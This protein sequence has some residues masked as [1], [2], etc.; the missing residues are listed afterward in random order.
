MPKWLLILFPVLALGGLIYW[1]LSRR[2]KTSFV[3]PA[4][5]QSVVG[6]SDVATFVNLLD[7]GD[8]KT[9]EVLAVIFK[10][11]SFI[12][13]AKAGSHYGLFQMY[14]PSLEDANLV[15][16]QN[17]KNPA[18]SV[19]WS[20]YK[21]DWRAQCRAGV[22][23]MR[24]C[25]RAAQSNKDLALKIWRVGYGCIMNG[26]GCIANAGKIASGYVEH[27][28]SVKQRFVKYDD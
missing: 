21:A 16:T 24:W 23:Y 27:F 18:A 19:S 10:E 5:G 13:T 15:L 26:T 22:A 4:T 28:H 20:E 6:E 7:R 2:E 8:W 11:S 17:G 14:E 12:P 25:F 3:T 9:S 1:L